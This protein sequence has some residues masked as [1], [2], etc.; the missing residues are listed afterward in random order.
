MGNYFKGDG[1]EAEK[2]LSDQF[3]ESWLDGW[4]LYRRQRL[5][6]DILINLFALL[7]RAS[8][9]NRMGVTGSY[10]TAHME[11]NSITRFWWR[12]DWR[13]R[14]QGKWRASWKHRWLLVSAA[15]SLWTLTSQKLIVG[16]WYAKRTGE[17]KPAEPRP[18]HLSFGWTRWGLSELHQQLLVEQID[19]F[20]WQ[21]GNENFS[22]WLALRSLLCGWSSFGCWWRNEMADSLAFSRGGG[23]GWCPLF[24]SQILGRFPI[25]LCWFLNGLLKIRD[26]PFGKKNHVAGRFHQ[27]DGA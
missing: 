8:W 21:T 19:G 27:G 3:K 13:T 1:C 17:S 10:M 20:D 18:P 12:T 11:C 26:R 5:R 23:D 9:R 2:I 22:F 24:L 16:S 14:G 25:G 15:S 7:P 4:C 6:G